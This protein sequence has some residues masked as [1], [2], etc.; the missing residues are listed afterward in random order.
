[1]LFTDVAGF[2]AWC[3]ERRDRPEEVVATLQDLIT[4][5]EASAQLHGA[6]KIKTVGDA[7]MAVAGLNDTDANPALTLL[8]CGLDLIADAAVH[9]AKWPVRVGIHVGPVVTGVLGQTQFTFDVWGHT[10]NAAA[11]MESNGIPGRVT[12]S[13]EAWADVS[14]AADAVPREAMVKGL[15]SAT[16]WDVTGLKETN[17]E[18]RHE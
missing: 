15:G 16:V 11:R 2:T 13:C 9:P 3:D 1:V 18:G 8:R 10:V 7:F 17:H 5:F 14:Q 6:Q 12:L 4:R